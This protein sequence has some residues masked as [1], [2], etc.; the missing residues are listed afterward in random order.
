[1]NL[2]NNF[3]LQY[4]NPI[5]FLL[6]LIFIIV[7]FYIY[8]KNNI[9]YAGSQTNKIIFGQSCS[10]S[11]KN[12]NL[13]KEYSLGYILAFQHINRLG[14]I[15]GK[16]LELI[17]YDDHYDSN[18]ALENVKTLIGYFNVFAIIGSVGTPTSVAIEDYLQNK[19]IP[20]IQPLTGTNILR[21]SF[22]ENIIHTRPSYYDELKLILDNIIKTNK[23]N[24]TILYQNDNFGI[25]CINDLQYLI[26]QKKYSNINVISYGSYDHGDI[27]LDNSIK[28]SFK[29]QDIYNFNDR[30]NNKYI[31]TIDS[32]IIIG[33]YTKI[34]QGIRYLKPIKNDISI[35]TISFAEINSIEN[36]ISNMSSN[37]LNNIFITQILPDS[38]NIN[39]N[40][41][42]LISSEFQFYKKNND[43][44]A[45]T[46][47]LDILRKNRLSNILIEGFINGLF[48]SE[49]LKDINNINRN[50]FVKEFYKKKKY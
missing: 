49:I 15:N 32:V 19:N 16:K 28:S 31:N 24:I 50:N 17:L 11:K 37:M 2:N 43:D 21:D 26:S 9:I 36:I 40:L 39:K 6:F 34:I 25:S 7:L 12:A 13:G 4:K 3:F 22:K 30:K 23:K 18:V 48:V 47:Y 41:M 33:P 44:M 42:N 1:M 5:I 45:N 20:I 8:I 14:G 10:L 27:L 38:N 46:L 29:L 35:Y